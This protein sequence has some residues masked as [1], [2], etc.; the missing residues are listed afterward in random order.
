VTRRF[1]TIVFGRAVLAAFLAGAA[2][3][4]V[5]AVPHAGDGAPAFS[6]P[7]AR[8]GTVTLAAYKGKPLYLNFFAS[9]CAPCNDEAG[10]V[11][12]LYAKYHRA[13]LAVIGVDELEDKVKA[14]G[15]ARRYAWPFAVALDGDG[16][17]VRSYGVVGLP[18]HV[19][20]DRHGKISL[21]RLGEMQAGEIQDA[22]EKIVAR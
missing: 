15:F 22:I 11:G 14:L 21:F 13:G 7:S 6:L 5:L 9:W 20:I 1:R 12:S 8:G 17:L 16:G 18:V 10:D 3:A 2:T 4:P 19:F